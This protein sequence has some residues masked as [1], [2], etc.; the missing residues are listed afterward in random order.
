M[1]NFPDWIKKRIVTNPRYEELKGSIKKFNV[2]TVCFNARC[3]NSFECFSKGHISFLILGDVCTRACGFCS[4]KSGQ[5][6]KGVDI[7]EPDKIARVVK[8]LKMRYVVITSVTRDDLADGG[9]GHFSHTVS[10]IRKINKDI[11]IELLVPDFSY[12][13]DALKLVIEA[14]PDVISHNIETVG[15]FYDTVRPDYIYSK[16]LEL[17]RYL[18]ENSNG[19]LVKSSIMLGLGEE[20]SEVFSTIEEIRRTGCNALVIG[21]YLKPRSDCL[22]VK[23][24]V[25]LDEFKA[26]EEFAYEIGFKHV[27]SHPF[28]RSSY[29]AEKVF[30]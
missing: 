15:S 8:E 25:P 1:V 17:L 24:F 11:K 20:K 23:R 28:A 30:S 2:Q 10:A 21:Q 26:Y 5:E 13:L 19:Y 27:L 4:V 16:G 9:A 14:R 7:K 12:K 6:P 18:S 29:L 22:E 3:P